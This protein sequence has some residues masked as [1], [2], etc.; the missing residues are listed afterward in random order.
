MTAASSEAD[1]GDRAATET[2]LEGAGRRARGSGGTRETP[3]ARSCARMSM[4]TPTTT[5]VCYAAELSS[6]MADAVAM[7]AHE[8][9][10][11]REG[12]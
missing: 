11:A 8:S 9:R 12:E 3:W 2:E 7:G 10:G 1:A 5:T 4:T 6:A